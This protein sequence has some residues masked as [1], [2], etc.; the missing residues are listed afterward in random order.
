VNARAGRRGFTLAELMVTLSVIAL[1]AL[2]GTPYFIGYWQTAKLRGGAEELATVLN[3]ARQLAIRN[4]TFV[5]VQRQAGTNRVRF[6]V[7]N[8]GCTGTTFV[9]AGTRSTGDIDLND[10][11]DVSAQTA[12]VVFNYL[13]AATT[14]GTYTVRNPSNNRTLSVVVAASGRVSI[15]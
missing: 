1:V 10:N 14:P 6:L 13:G 7:G 15:Q 5:C 8:S 11:V 4:N 12:S 2:A 9:G 3:R